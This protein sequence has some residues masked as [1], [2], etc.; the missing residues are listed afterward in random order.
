MLLGVGT[1]R[2]PMACTISVWGGMLF[3][4]GSKIAIMGFLSESLRC[5]IVRDTLTDVE[6]LISDFASRTR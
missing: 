1:S 2:N 6:I 3:Y 5:S 4:G